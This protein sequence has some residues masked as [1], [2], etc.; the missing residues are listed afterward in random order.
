MRVRRSVRGVSPTN[1]LRP[2][3]AALSSQQRESRRKGLSARREILIRVGPVAL[4][5]RLCDTPTADRIWRALPIYSTAE[6]WGQSIHFE[7]PIETGRERGATST[8]TRGDILFWVEENRVVIAFGPTP[9]SKPPEMRL[10][11][12]CNVWAVALD[13]VAALAAVQPGARAAILEADS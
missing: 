2:S 11:A 9:I 4:R 3:T 10:P 7:T 6:T 5:A 1:I 8:A 13:D 12:P